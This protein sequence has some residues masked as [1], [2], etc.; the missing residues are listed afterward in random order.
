MTTS[1]LRAL[2]LLL[3][4]AF[5]AL[6][7]DGAARHAW[8]DAAIADDYEDNDFA[9]PPG[10][11]W[12][13]PPPQ[14]RGPRPN[15]A[16]RLVFK[17]RIAPHWFDENNR[18][19]YRNDLPAGAKE[20]IL[21]DAKDG[22]AALAF[23]HQK[24]AAAL[25]KAIGGTVYKADRL[26]FDEIDFVDGSKAVRFVFDKATWK[27]SLDDY[28]CSRTEPGKAATPS[29]PDGDE[30]APR[31]RRPAGERQGP[32]APGARQGLRSPDGKWTAFVKDRN[33]FVRAEG[34]SEEIPLSKDGKEGLAYGRLSWSPDSKTLVAFR[35]EP[36]ERKEVYLIESSPPGGGRA[37]LRPRPTPCPATSSPPTSSTSSTSPRRKRS[38]PRSIGSTSGAGRPLGRGRAAFHL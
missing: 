27:C 31:R 33:V 14:Q 18:F 32:D 36:G 16:D 5:L 10:D 35:I 38:V 37:K 20:F 8:A 21:V 6:S 23:D 17:M 3:G 28:T 2:V 24:L 26:P 12:Y 4:F 29:S 25:S 30:N 15:A 11:P 1:R 13:E 9:P 19:W 7:A 22:T 34:K